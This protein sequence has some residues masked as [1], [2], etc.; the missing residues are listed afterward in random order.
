MAKRVVAGARP[1]NSPP[2]AP[3]CAAWGLGRRDVCTP[4]RR[5]QEIEEYPQDQMGIDPPQDL[6]MVIQRAIDLR[7]T[8]GPG[9]P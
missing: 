4:Q 9:E 6:P 1:D 8:P 5:E 7:E 2:L 3:T